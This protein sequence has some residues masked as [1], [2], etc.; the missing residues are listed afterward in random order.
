MVPSQSPI[1]ALGE[2]R[3]LLS[4]II[5]IVVKALHTIVVGIGVVPRFGRLRQWMVPG[6]FEAIRFEDVR[7]GLDAIAGR[8]V[9]GHVDI[10]RSRG[11]RVRVRTAHDLAR[12]DADKIRRIW[13]LSRWG[14]RVLGA[15]RE[16]DHDGES[17]KN[18][19]QE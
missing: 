14:S 11:K 7:S 13:I 18:R 19:Q 3:S 15:G 2:F 9:I 17:G 1:R 5:R 4:Q 8:A 12:P 16:S 10:V 6:C